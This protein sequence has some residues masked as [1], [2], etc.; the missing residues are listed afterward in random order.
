VKK[1]NKFLIIIVVVLAIVAA[2]TENHYS[3]LSSHESDF[4]VR[5]TASVTKI[6]IADN[7]VNQALLE[8][9]QHGWLLNKKFPANKRS[10]DF[11]LETVRE[12]RV[13]APVSKAS[14]NN[15]IKRL[16]GS[17]IKVEI[18]QNVPRINLF[19][20]VKLFYHE[21]L[22]KVF[23]VGGVT[24]N[25]LGTYMLM[26]GAKHAYIVY[27]P[28]FRGFVSVRFTPKEDDWK[29][30]IV[31]NKSLADIKSVEVDNSKNPKK[32]FKVIVI[33]AM[34]TFGLTR[35]E[36]G[37]KVMNYDTLKLLNFLTSFKDLRYESRLNNILGPQKIDSILHTKPIF[38]IRLVDMKD[39]TTQ[40]FMYNKNRFPDAVSKA[41]EELVPVDLDRLYGS[42]NKGEDFVLMQY[43]VFDKVLRPL[44]YYERKIKAKR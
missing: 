26:D 25:N 10:V 32:S 13:K 35:L 28:G 36:D 30:H 31:F 11:L 44:D 12:I 21:K 40:V 14:S 37:S 7:N 39:D 8:R 2:F 5:D 27:I 3:T 38:I 43:Y 29:S 6:F 34:G 15:V 20:R 9:T 22:T 23:F 18:Y 1:R 42:I 17:S 19:N 41:Y 4:S 33:D 16:A 24:Q